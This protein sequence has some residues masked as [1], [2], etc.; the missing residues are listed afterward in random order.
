MTCD[1]SFLFSATVLMTMALI[2]LIGDGSTTCHAVRHLAHALPLVA[3]IAV[4]RIYVVPKPSIVPV[5]TL[6][7]MLAISTIPVVGAMPRIHVVPNTAALPPMLAAVPPIMPKLTLPLMPV[8][9][10]KVGDSPPMPVVMPKVG[11]LPPM[12][13][14]WPVPNRRCPLSRQHWSPLGPTNVTRTR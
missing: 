2:M 1:T 7:L 4:S 11:D 6:P 9:R 13:Y 10:P 14:V 5:G 8:V 12:S 3:P